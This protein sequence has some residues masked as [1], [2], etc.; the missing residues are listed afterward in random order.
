[1]IFVTSW[2]EKGKTLG[3]PVS[4]YYLSSL[5]KDDKSPEAWSALIRG[6]WAG[7]E[8]RNHWRKDACLFEDKTRSRNPN[9]VGS[10]ILLRN[11]LLRVFDSQ[12]DTYDSL[13]SLV[14][15]I[16]AKP[17]LAIDAIRKRLA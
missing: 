11:A 15:S 6:H 17:Q 5:D 12:Q 14:E 16:A 9:I 8:N 3:A 7:V 13:P 2:R 1:L 10:L 4:R